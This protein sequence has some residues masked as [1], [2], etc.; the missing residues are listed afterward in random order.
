M[1]I[2][3]WGTRATWFQSPRL[4]RSGEKTRLEIPACITGL[5][6]NF[7]RC[8]IS[9][10]H[11]NMWSVET[12]NTVSFRGTGSLFMRLLALRD[13][14]SHH[15][16]CAPNNTK[17]SLSPRLTLVSFNSVLNRNTAYEIH[18]GLKIQRACFQM[19]AHKYRI[20]EEAR[21]NIWIKIWNAF[22]K[23]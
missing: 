4:S 10:N 14:A 12:R 23:R 7:P 15:A 16:P 13:W 8:T 18:L 1:E 22:G 2:E 11:N 17:S 5:W 3:F 19:K 21:R 6:I 9:F 20:A